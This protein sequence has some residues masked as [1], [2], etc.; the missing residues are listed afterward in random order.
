MV[1]CTKTIK[2][3][4]FKYFV[5]ITY[6]YAVLDAYVYKLNNGYDLRPHIIPVNC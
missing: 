1:H 3:I 5:K 2:V 6:T 4:S